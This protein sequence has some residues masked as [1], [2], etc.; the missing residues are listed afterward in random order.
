MHRQLEEA[1]YI[2][3]ENFMS[4][5]LLSALRTRVDELFEQE[6]EDAGAEFRQEPNTRRLANLVDKGAAFQQIIVMPE[7]LA[8]VT[9]VLGPDFKLSSL[10][11]RSANPHS[12]SGQPLHADMGLIADEKG[13]SVCNTVWI[14]DDFTPEN[15][16][17]RVIPGSHRLGK[18]P[19]DVLAD[20]AAPHPE[21]VLITG[22]AGTVVVMNAHAWHGGTANR[23][24]AHRRAL[25][26]FYCR[27]DKPQQQYQKALLRVETQARL[28]PALRK[29]LALDDPL[30]DEISSKTTRQSGF[31]RD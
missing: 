31:L 6:G 9:E 5:G 14:L 19:Q 1:G 28:S 16:A 8:A 24:A 30:N 11:A 26:A 23:T 29:V 27:A 7:I 25:H 2:I 15:G 21:E 22:R 20:L 13:Y 18:L 12:N 3:L 10:N 17:L 4:P